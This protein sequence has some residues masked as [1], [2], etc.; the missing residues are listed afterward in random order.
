MSDIRLIIKD[1]E[2]NSEDK[3]VLVAGMLSHH[4]N[5]GHPRKSETFSIFL[6]YL[7]DE[8]LGG[9]IVCFLWKGMEIQSLWVDESVRKEGWGK[10]LL[11]GAEEEA[12]KRGCTIAYTNTF[13]WQA[14]EFY[15]KFGYTLFGKLEEFPEGNTL[16]Y[17]YKKLT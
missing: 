15:E 17:F 13:S 11:E 7:D 8:V 16:K 2:P 3:K 10:K 6:K 4:A 14:P 12:K 1:G 9:I 5:K